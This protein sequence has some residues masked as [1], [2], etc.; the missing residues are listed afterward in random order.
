M[1]WVKASPR[2]AVR[3]TVEVAAHR[4]VVFAGHGSWNTIT[5]ARDLHFTLPKNTRM[6]FWVPHGEGLDDWLGGIVDPRAH[7]QDLEALVRRLGERFGQAPGMPE[8]VQGGQRVFNYRLTPPTGLTLGNSTGQD[9]R[10]ITMSLPPGVAPNAPVAQR[11]KTIRELFTEHA[12]I[13][14]GSTIYWSACRSICA[15]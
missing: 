12:D 2:G 13:C 7:L 10:F 14:A 5:D 9:P 11:S 15:R 4:R 6:V 1:N 3:G 8:I